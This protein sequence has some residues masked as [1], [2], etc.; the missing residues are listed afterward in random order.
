MI[1]LPFEQFNLTPMGDGRLFLPVKGHSSSLRK[2]AG[3][4]VEVEL[5]LDT[6]DVELRC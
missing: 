6:S 1:I 2:E 4:W 5:F 3:D